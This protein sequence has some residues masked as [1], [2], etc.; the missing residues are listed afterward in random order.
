MKKVINA[1][2]SSRFTYKITDYDWKLIS[3]GYKGDFWEPSSPAETEAYVDIDFFYNGK[4]RLKGELNEDTLNDIDVRCDAD[5]TPT[6]IKKAY[7]EEV[8]RTGE[9]TAQSVIEAL[10]NFD[11]PSISDEDMDELELELFIYLDNWA[12]V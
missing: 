7:K 2:T 3:E 5:D 4:L 1:N 9:F 11:Y 6:E 10:E 12:W 8:K